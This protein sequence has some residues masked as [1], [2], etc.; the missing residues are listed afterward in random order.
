[1]YVDAPDD[2][3]IDLQYEF[4]GRNI[5]YNVTFTMENITNSTLVP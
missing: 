5:S 2:L 4:F 1:M 3:S